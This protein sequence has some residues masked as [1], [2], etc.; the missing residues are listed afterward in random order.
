MNVTF[1][2]VPNG[3]P[4][5]QSVFTIKSGQDMVIDT[6]KEVHQLTVSYVGTG[7]SDT[8]PSGKTSA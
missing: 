2:Q 1:T 5:P 3:G 4:Y 8:P 7:L 6:Y